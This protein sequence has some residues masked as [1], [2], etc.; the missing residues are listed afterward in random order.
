MSFFFLIFL[1]Y[2]PKKIIYQNLVR[3]E[4]RGFY[5]SSDTESIV[6]SLGSTEEVS[7]MWKEVAAMHATFYSQQSHPQPNGADAGIKSAAFLTP[8][9]SMESLSMSSVTPK[10][11]K[12]VVCFGCFQYVLN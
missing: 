4:K 8:S 9:V 11:R 12:E 2:G 7:K 3:L 5:P 1:E 10:V 6:F